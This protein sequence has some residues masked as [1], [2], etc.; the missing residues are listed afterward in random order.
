ML[1]STIQMTF[2]ELRDYAGI[3]IEGNSGGTGISIQHGYEILDKFG[4]DMAGNIST[5]VNGDNN[6]V[7]GATGIYKVTFHISAIAGGTNKT[8]AFS[9]FEITN[10]GTSITSST[11]ATPVSVLAVANGFVTTNK[12]KIVGVTTAEELNDRVF[13]I[14]RTDNDNF[15]LHDDNGGNINGTGFGGAGTGG[16]VYLATEHLMVHADRKF[17]AAD[18]GQASGGG[19]ASL[20]AANAIEMYVKN[21]TDAVDITFETV[22]FMLQRVG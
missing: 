16:T 15:T 10:A 20:T 21:I 9:M 13:T 1:G 2:A 7:V 8:Y 17:A 6:I 22:Q 14:T 4:S 5:G 18:V 11:A 12:V 19:Y 3:Y